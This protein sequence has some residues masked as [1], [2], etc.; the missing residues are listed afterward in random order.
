MTD[1]A[2]AR[3][4]GEVALSPA[5]L[6]DVGAIQRI[7]TEAGSRFVEIGMSTIAADD[8]PTADE[9][10]PAIEAGRVLIARVAGRPVGYIWWSVLDGEG[11]IDQVSVTPAAAGRGIGRRLIDEVCA[12][13]AA[14]GH[15]YV[16]LTTFRDVAWNRPL[17][18]RYGFSVVDPDELSGKLAERRRAERESGIEVQARVAMRRDLHDS[19]EGGRR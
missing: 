19:E 16:T 3:A 1:D 5:R 17:Y 6:V 7:E 2:I 12:A 9:L 14:S 10:R 13:A 8:P 4:R 11:H 15:R 18:E